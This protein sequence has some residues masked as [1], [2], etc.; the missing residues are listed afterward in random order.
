MNKKTILKS[1]KKRILRLQKLKNKTD[2]VLNEL[3]SLRALEFYYL[4]LVD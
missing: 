1:L 4:F 2:E 3:L